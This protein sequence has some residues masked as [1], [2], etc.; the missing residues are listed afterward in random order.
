M[1]RH[2]TES[3]KKHKE[4]IELQAKEITDEYDLEEF[5]EYGVDRI[6]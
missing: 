6:Q 5:W 2:I 1:E 3:T 4:A